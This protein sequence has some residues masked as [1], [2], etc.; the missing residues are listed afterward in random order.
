[1]GKN[2]LSAAVDTVKSAAKKHSPEILMGI[3]IAGMISTTVLAVEATPKALD[4][5]AEINEEHAED[6]DKKAYTKDVI[7]RVAPVYIPSAIICGLSIACLIG[8]SSVNFRRNA[9]LATAYSLS[10]SALR[11]Y[12]DKITETFGEKKERS[13]RDSIAK[14][15]IDKDPVENHDVI[16]TK[17]GDTLCYEYLSGRYFKSDYD[18]LQRA[19]NDLNHK[20]LCDDYVSLNDLYDE[21]GLKFNGM[22]DQLGWRV[23]RGLIKLDISAQLTSQNEPCLVI[24]YETRPTYDYDR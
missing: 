8:A 16:V 21:I 1:M 3:G 6:T 23:D 11:E 19:V 13:I 20:M 4:I 22:G 14:D 9:A 7:T 2:N 5:M 15:R 12:Q 24:D 10:E 17:D 18:R